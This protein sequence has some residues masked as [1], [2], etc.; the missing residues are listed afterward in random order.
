[1]EAAHN[2][3]SMASWEPL[4]VSTEIGPVL[5]LQD[6]AANIEGL[7]PSVEALHASFHDAADHLNEVQSMHTQV[8][9]SAGML[10]ESH[11]AETEPERQLKW[12]VEA[13]H[14]TVNPD[15][16]TIPLLGVTA[17]DVAVFTK[18]EGE[19]TLLR[20]VISD[21]ENEP[22]EREMP[23]PDSSEDINAHY[24]NGRLHLRW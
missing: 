1:M 15:G 23:L 16:L 2:R 13:L 10:R 3:N 21:G 18:K 9:I 8:L 14:G 20:L 6:K 17:E 7:N 24:V 5:P 11:L 4:D 19:N 12:M 22:L